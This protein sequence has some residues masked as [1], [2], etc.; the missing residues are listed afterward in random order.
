[1]PPMWHAAS[2][3]HAPQSGAGV[4][5]G[6]YV[7]AAASPTAYTMRRAQGRRPP[8][9]RSG[10]VRSWH[11]PVNPPRLRAVLSAIG[12]RAN[13][14]TRP[15]NGGLSR[16]SLRAMSGVFYN[17]ADL[18]PHRSR[19]WLNAEPDEAADETIADLTTL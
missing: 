14:P 17:Q 12:P 8:S 10:G 9:A 1:M 2:A 7:T 6:L 19:Y 3:R 18:Q 13:W 16:P 11:S 5:T 15:A 4:V